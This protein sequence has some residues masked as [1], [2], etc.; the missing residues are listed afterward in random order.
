[1]NINWYSI[2]VQ[3]RVLGFVTNLCTEDDVQMG[4]FIS[5]H[6]EQAEWGFQQ[7]HFNGDMI[8]IPLNPE[9]VMQYIPAN[10]RNFN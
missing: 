4:Y 5:P 2:I 3:N 9:E 1:M 10:V 8:F 7:L 6:I